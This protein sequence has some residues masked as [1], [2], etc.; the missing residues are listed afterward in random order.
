MMAEPPSWMTMSEIDG[1]WTPYDVVDDYGFL[2]NAGVPWRHRQLFNMLIRF[3]AETLDSEVSEEQMDFYLHKTGSLSAEHLRDKVMRYGLASN[4]ERANE[5]Y[6]LDLIKLPTTTDEA[7]G[8]AAA[9]VDVLA[10]LQQAASSPHARRNEAARKGDE[11]CPVSA[12][13]DEAANESAS[14]SPHEAEGDANVKVEADEAAPRAHAEAEGKEPWATAR[15]TEAKSEVASKLPLKR[16]ASVEAARDDEDEEP[17]DKEKSVAAAQASVPAPVQQA[18]SS[19]HARRNEAAGNEDARKEDEERPVSAETGAEPAGAGAAG[20]GATVANA[21]SATVD[22]PPVTDANDVEMSLQAASSPHAR[23]NGAARKGDEACPVSAEADEAANESSS[24]SPHEAEGDANVK[25][26]ADEAAP[27]A[28][29][30]AEGK[31]P[32][33]TARESSYYALRTYRIGS[34]RNICRVSQKVTHSMRH[35]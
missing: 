32:W 8:V 10:P 21:T 4:A 16:K 34:F 20:E 7:E 17:M 33:A 11:A 1:G 29:A 6:M 27:R 28:H 18:A 31:E 26:E 15:E 3:P 2:E 35:A 12:E 22:A 13:A 23:R 9:Q 5:E 19:P 30:E 14:R 24:R 25:V